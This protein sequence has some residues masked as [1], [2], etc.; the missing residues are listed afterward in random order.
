MTEK[1]FTATV[2]A[3]DPKGNTTYITKTGTT[4]ESARKAAVRW[5]VAYY[6]YDNGHITGQHSAK[7]ASEQAGKMNLYGELEYDDFTF[8]FVETPVLEAA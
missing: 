6:L 8:E 7:I 2:K 5:G 1:Q 3:T 4:L